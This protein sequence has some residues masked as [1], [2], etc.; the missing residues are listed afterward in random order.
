MSEKERLDERYLTWVRR[1]HEASGDNPQ[2][3]ENIVTECQ[4]AFAESAELSENQRAD[5]Y[6][7]IKTKMEARAAAAFEAAANLPLSL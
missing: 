5:I 7:S 3:V 6:R 2:D 4:R 1:K